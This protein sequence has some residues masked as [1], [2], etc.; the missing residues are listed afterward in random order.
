MRVRTNI[1]IEEEILEK[2]DEIAGEK[3]KRAAVIKKALLEFIAKE[4]KRQAKNPKPEE[5]SEKTTAKN[6]RAAV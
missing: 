3:K 1:I 6:K 2:I 4:E 5:P